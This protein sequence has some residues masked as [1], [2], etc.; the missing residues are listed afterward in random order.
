MGVRVSRS[1]CRDPL[2]GGTKHRSGILEASWKICNEYS[3]M[4]GQQFAA[5]RG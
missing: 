3:F 4:T 1:L 2:Y 5:L